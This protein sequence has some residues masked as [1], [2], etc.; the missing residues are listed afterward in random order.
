MEVVPDHF[1]VF[2]LLR[3]LFGFDTIETPEYLMEV[4]SVIFYHFER[5]SSLLFGLRRLFLFL[6]T[7]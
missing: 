5:P 4:L 1:D 3:L 6:T 2:F 7:L